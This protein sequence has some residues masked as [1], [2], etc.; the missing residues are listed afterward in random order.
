MIYAIRRINLNKV[1]HIPAYFIPLGKIKTVKV[2]TGEKTKGFFGG[3]KD[4]VRREEQ[5]IQ[6]G[7]SDR[8]ID[9]GRLARD[10]Q[11]TVSM[12]NEEGYEVLTVTPVTSGAYDWNYDVSSGGNDYNGYGGYGYGYGYSYTDSLIVVAKKIG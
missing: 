10:L 8:E 11:A 5:W 3:E 4:V 6:T 9:S 12:L 1:I 2:P 7:I